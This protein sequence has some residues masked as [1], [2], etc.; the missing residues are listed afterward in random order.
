MIG[1]IHAAHISEF[2]GH[3]FAVALATR[4]AGNR[5]A[6]YCRLHNPAA[7]AVVLQIPAIQVAQFRCKRELNDTRC[8]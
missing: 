4:P 1:A 5:R 6:E 3:R 8:G 2:V 7:N